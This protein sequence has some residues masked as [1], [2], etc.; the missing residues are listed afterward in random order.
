MKALT[1]VLIVL[2]IA[3]RPGLVW[4]D[5]HGLEGAGTGLSLSLPLLP[6]KTDFDSILERPLFSETRS[7]SQDTSDDQP[8]SSA[9]ELREQWKLTAVILTGEQMTALFR[10]RNGVLHRQLQT[11]MPLDDA[12]VLSEI[13]DTSVVLVA[14]DNE[15]RL[16][17]LEPRN[18]APLISDSPQSTDSGTDTDSATA[19]Q[20]SAD[21]R[22]VPNE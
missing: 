7:P 17:L 14:G 5:E 6:P 2:C 12:W 10:Q 22:E 20:D 13:D 18:T 15:V 11:G 3:G 8:V 21:P 19:A 1:L 16:Q 9:R 4:A